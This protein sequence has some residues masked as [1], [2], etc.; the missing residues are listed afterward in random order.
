M[1][2]D[3][4]VPYESNLRKLLCVSHSRALH[5]HPLDETSQTACI[6]TPSLESA[7]K[8]AVQHSDF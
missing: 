5:T 8:R 7:S 6:V 4:T 3:E 1:G 2:C